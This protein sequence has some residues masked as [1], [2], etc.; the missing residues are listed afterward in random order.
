MRCPTFLRERSGAGGDTGKEGPGKNR[1]QVPS[2]GGRHPNV[3]QVRPTFA[4]PPKGCERSGGRHG[5]DPGQKQKQKMGPRPGLQVPSWGTRRN[6]FQVHPP[7]LHNQ[8]Q[9]NGG[10]PSE[11]VRK[12]RGGKRLGKRKVQVKSGSKC[13]VGG[14]RP[15]VFQAPTL[16]SDGGWG[17]KS[18]LLSPQTWPKL[19]RRSFWARAAGPGSVQSINQSALLQD[20]ASGVPALGS[21]GSGEG[22]GEEGRPREGVEEKGINQGGPPLGTDPTGGQQPPPR[23]PSSPAPGVPR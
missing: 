11:R 12:A 14:G 6:V 1:V 8:T 9:G 22:E 5:K 16:G 4:P 13:Q 2:W 3:F 15:N 21:G 20:L 18:H 10:G 23:G 7:F 17:S 19:A